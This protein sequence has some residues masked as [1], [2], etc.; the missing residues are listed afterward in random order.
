MEFR[1]ISVRDSTLRAGPRDQKCERSASPL[2]V[3]FDVEARRIVAMF[4]WIDIRAVHN[5]MKLRVEVVP[6][7]LFADISYN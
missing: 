6:T 2:F 5:P 1:R 4:G 7:L 3:A